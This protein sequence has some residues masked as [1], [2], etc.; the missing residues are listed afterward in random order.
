MPVF[1]FR[2]IELGTARQSATVVVVEG[3]KIEFF[4]EFAV[5][6]LLCFLEHGEVFVELGLVFESGAVN[7]LELRVVFGAFVVGAGDIR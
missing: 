5:V 1:L 2:V 3:K 4:A 7:A 6:A